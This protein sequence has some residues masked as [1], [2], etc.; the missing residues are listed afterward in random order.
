[1]L[2]VELIRFRKTYRLYS[3]LR[4]RIDEFNS[5]SLTEPNSA[6]AVHIVIRLIQS[7]VKVWLWS[8][9]GCNGYLHLFQMRLCQYNESVRQKE[10]LATRIDTIQ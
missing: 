6:A 3:R 8:S 2:Q 7:V 1:M 10:Q 4:L 9:T 5:I